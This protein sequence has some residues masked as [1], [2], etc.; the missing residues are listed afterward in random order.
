MKKHVC[1]MLT[2][3]A[4]LIFNPSANANAVKA[5]ETKAQAEWS[6]LI[7]IN[8]HNNLDEYGKMNINQMEQ[9][10]SSKD[11]NVLVQWASL[12]EGT[13]RRLRIEKDNSSAVTSPVLQDLGQI[14][15][16]DYRQLTDFINW[17]VQNYPAKKY[18]VAVWNHGNGWNLMRAENGSIK[19]QDI[20]YD[21]ITGSKI[22]TEELGVVM[23]DAAKV[24]GHKVDV[25][26]SDACLM[27]MVEIATE[28]MDSVGHFLGSQELEPGEGW[29]YEEFLSRLAKKPTATP[30]EFSNYLVEEYY[31]AYTGGVYG[32]KDVT[33]SALDLAELGNLNAALAVLAKELKTQSGNALASLKA[34]NK[35]AQRFYRGDYKDLGNLVTMIGGN[36]KITVD[37]SAIDNVKTALNKVIIGNKVTSKYR[38]ASGLSIWSPEWKSD[39]EENSKRYLGLEFHRQSGWGEVIEAITSK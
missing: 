5:S 35:L 24:I 15:M 11:I 32:H 28:M 18:F 33:F 23:R 31:S 1:L 29:P 26:G 20:S 6:L 17:G 34:T 30:A 39:Y 22:T 16:G 3:L 27:A 21:D 10:G 38:K 8:G 19:P 13:V 12:E 2:F 36:S 4:T 25:Y 9:V 37:K 7:F 14:D